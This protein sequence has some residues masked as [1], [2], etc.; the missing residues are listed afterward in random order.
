MAF[1][2][3]FW[4]LSVG[5]LLAQQEPMATQWGLVQSHLNP[6][7]TG[8]DKELHLTALYRRQWVGIEGAPSHP[9][10]VATAPFR[11]G[12]STQ[13]VGLVVSAEKKGLFTETT[14]MAQVGLGFRLWG[15]RLAFGVE[16]GLY[17]M[18]FDGTK[19]FI[20]EGEE[21]NPNDPA[22]PLTRVGGRGF[23]CGAGVYYHHPR[24]SVGIASRHLLANRIFLENTYYIKLAR[25]YNLM[26]RGKLG[27]K[28]AALQWYPSLLAVTDLVGYR[29][30]VALDMALRERFFAGLMFR[31][32]QAAGFQLGYKWGTVR[33][34]YAFEMPISVLARG[35]WGTHELL[36]SYALALNPPVNRNIKQVSARLL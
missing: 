13:G 9:M 36:L 34:G 1:L 15:G 35:N 21:L 28:D 4:L 22:I 32:I 5:L 29:V 17:N 25:T 11:L 18:V 6:A 26:V 3:V 7:A 16:A 20:P 2:A 19:V 8:L 33:V 23:D 14:A 12:L 30:D 24:F 10:L 27:K 31:P